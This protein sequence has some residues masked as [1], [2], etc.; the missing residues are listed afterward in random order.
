MHPVNDK[1]KVKI[2]DSDLYKLGG[3]SV[4]KESGL[5]VEVP[6]ELLYFG[7][8]SFAFEKSLANKEPLSTVIDFYK[9][10]EGK[11]V[12]WEPLQD[13]GRHFKEGEDEFVFLNMTDVLAWADS[14]ESIESINQLGS[15]GAFNLQ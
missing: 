8:H 13:S 10:L 3:D 14:S 11:I 1:L 9:K 4:G 6:N 2:I 7:F 12:F 5:V 15:A